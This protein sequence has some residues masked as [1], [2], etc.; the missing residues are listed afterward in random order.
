[1]K[2]RLEAA[3]KNVPVVG[4]QAAAAA[5]T[6]PAANL[7]LRLRFVGAGQAHR[8][9]GTLVVGDAKT[10]P[11]TFEILPVDIGKDALKIE[12]N[13]VEVA[14][15]TVP[16]APVGIDV[17]VDPGVAPVTWDLYL[18]DRPWPDEAVY[19]G[20]YGLFAPV[21]RKGVASDEAR[22]AAHATAFPPL[23]G[24]RDL[25]LFVVRERRSEAEGPT[26]TDEGAEEMARLLKEWG[27][28]HGSK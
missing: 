11:K 4:T 7:P 1:M 17:V 25:G 21:L 10:K 8:V 14:F 27:Y 26:T 20:P 18:D 6:T 5:P 12:G 2:A 22:A 16:N 9:S 13:K 15:T 19:G 23:D 3:L 24:K 28:A